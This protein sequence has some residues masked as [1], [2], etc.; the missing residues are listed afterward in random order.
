MSHVKPSMR[1][2][3][4]L[5]EKEIDEIEEEEEEVESVTSAK[6]GKKRRSL[7]FLAV[8]RAKTKKFA[9]EPFLNSPKT[10]VMNAAASLKQGTSRS[11][12]KKA[13]EDT[14]ANITKGSM[15]YH[16]IS[17]L[18]FINSCL[19]TTCGM[20][21]SHQTSQIQTKRYACLHDMKW[22]IMNLISKYM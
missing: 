10:D 12:G 13:V 15:I 9:E 1:S 11:V 5:H 19:F 20:C 18:I 8:D 3:N 16:S 7:D 2:K 14:T 22:N 4:L 17:H 6:K 21:R